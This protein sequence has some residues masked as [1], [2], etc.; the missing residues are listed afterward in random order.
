MR[1]Y[2]K[3][4]AIDTLEKAVL[5]TELN[6]LGEA[7]II[8]SAEKLGRGKRVGVRAANAFLESFAADAKFR[9]SCDVKAVINGGLLDEDALIS[10][11]W[12]G[13]QVLQEMA[14]SEF[15]EIAEE[16]L[17]V[18]SNGRLSVNKWVDAVITEVKA[19][20]VE[21]LYSLDKNRGMI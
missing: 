1:K 5:F 10:L 6:F 18:A 11:L 13:T 12:Q 21:Y 7:F 16:Q 9:L 15:I 2:Y 14:I 20:A 8:N 19:K 17:S 3:E 4:K